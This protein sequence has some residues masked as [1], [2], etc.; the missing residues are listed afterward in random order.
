MGGIY[1]E[2]ALYATPFFAESRAPAVEAF[3]ENFHR[4]YQSTPSYLE[5]QA[6]DALMLLMLARSD[7][8]AASIER[9]SLLNNLL[10]I[11]KYEGLTGTCSFTPEG[12]LERDYMVLQIVNG[13]TV[14]VY[15]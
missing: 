11:R 1:V 10:R 2:Q 13:Q 8:P 14:Q 12:N 6:Y 4:L 7:L 15:P 9:L 3:R 5:A